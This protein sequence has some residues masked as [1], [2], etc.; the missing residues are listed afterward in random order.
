MIFGGLS[1]LVAFLFYPLGQL[2]ALIAWPFAAYTIRIVELFAQPAWAGLALAPISLAGIFA[3]YALM[4]VFTFRPK[5]TKFTLPQMRP[6][7]AIFALV[8]LN[9]WV[10]GFV[11]AAPDGAL[12]ITLLNVGDGEAL[13]LRTP[14]GRNLLI[15]GG[16]SQV[17][18]AEELGRSLPR[19]QAELDWL[20][21]GGVGEQQ[22]A[23]LADAL[24]RLA[25]AQIAWF[26]S[27]SANY[28]A[29][30]LRA[31]ATDLSLS[32]EQRRSG[33][34]FDLGGGAVLEVLAVSNEGAVLLLQ[35]GNFRALLPV[36]M[37]ADNLHE[38]AWGADVGRVDALLLAG[39][40]DPA[41]N[42]ANW[43]EH[44]DPGVVLL[45]LDAANSA[46]LPDSEVLDALDGRTIL[47][48]DRDGWIRLTTDGQQMWLQSAR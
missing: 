5:A 35:M 14:A 21:V 45:S 25:P 1:V 27:L 46:G 24:E 18:L 39:A 10:W 15:N 41:L 36:G 19:A 23:A 47:R 3:A 6:A 37:A 2:L 30:Q 22:I 33:E 9:L 7:A 29:R 34:A 8:L 12:Q 26:G 38:L 32:L 4:G 28:E 31:A 44:L 40:G 42:P 17:R 16:A 11:F 13:L 20:I 48:T 43:L